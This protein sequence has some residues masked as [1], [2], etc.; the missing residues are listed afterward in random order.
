MHVT[1]WGDIFI[2]IFRGQKFTYQPSQFR[3]KARKV[4]FRI[5][6]NDPS[7]F[8]HKPPPHFAHSSSSITWNERENCCSS[9]F[10]KRSNWPFGWPT[11]TAVYCSNFTKYLTF[12]RYMFSSCLML[13]ASL[14][15][16]SNSVLLISTLFVHELNDIK[17][18]WKFRD[19]IGSS[20]MSGA[21]APAIESADFV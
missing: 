10:R 19:A 4:Y 16:L 20:R 15:L 8:E 2:F 21:A 11:S 13:R 7:H 14:S 3:E 6:D 18:A 12:S 17:V 1:Q 5:E 9:V